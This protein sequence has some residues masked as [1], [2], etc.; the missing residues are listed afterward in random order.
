ALDLDHIDKLELEYAKLPDSPAYHP[1]IGH[2]PPLKI[3]PEEPFV[4]N[5]SVTGLSPRRRPGGLSVFYRNSSQAAYTELPMQLTNEFVD[6]WSA[7]IPAEAVVPGKLEYYF[8]V[9]PLK[10][11]QSNLKNLVQTPYVVLVNNNNEKP[12]ISHQEPPKGFR[13]RIVRL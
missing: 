10:W 7:T 5:V 1:A 9:E 2:V 4:I 8:E 11:N 12:Q 3:K 6:T 13:G